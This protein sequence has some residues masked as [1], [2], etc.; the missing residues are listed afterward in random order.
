MLGFDQLFMV[1]F[2]ETV[3]RHPGERLVFATIDEFSRTLGICPARP[4]MI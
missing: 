3:A 4:G 1:S 2:P